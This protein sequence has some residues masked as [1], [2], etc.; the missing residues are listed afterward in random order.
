MSDSPAK[1]LYPPYLNHGSRGG[2]VDH[3]HT[4]LDG[5]GFGEGIVADLE[6]GQVTAE[7]VTDLQ[8]WLGVEE[9]GDFGPTTRARR[10]RRRP[11]STLTKSRGLP[12]MA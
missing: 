9:D 8:R 10:S 2:A 7:R 3:L 12:R 11:T 4:L 6:Y 5:F 1:M